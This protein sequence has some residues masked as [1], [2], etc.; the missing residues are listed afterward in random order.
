ME[1][2]PAKMTL[3]TRDERVYGELKAAHREH[4]PFVTGGAPYLVVSLNVWFDGA[5]A[6]RAEL[7]EFKQLEWNGG[8]PPPV[9]VEFEWRYG[10]Q[11]WRVGY[12][13]YVGSVY[14]ILKASHGE[15]HLYLRNMQFRPIRTTE[16]ITAEEREKGIVEM[17]RSMMAGT[18]V[19]GDADIAR[20]TKLYDAGYRKQVA[21]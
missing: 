14:V 15:Q 2:K 7:V 16:Q 9:G 17:A 18:V 19:A 20:A 21:E 13:L 10:D 12:A 6:A 3:T 8:G 11:G 5:F 1:L 4:T